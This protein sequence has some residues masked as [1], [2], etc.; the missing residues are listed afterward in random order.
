[1][2]GRGQWT[3]IPTMIEDKQLWKMTT[4]NRLIKNE[5]YIGNIVWNKRRLKSVGSKRSVLNPEDKWLRAEGTHEAIVTKEL[6]D[7][8]N[9]EIAKNRSSYYHPSS[10]KNIVYK[11]LF[12]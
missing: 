5:V 4:I 10:K 8:A 6:F 7:K 9:G 1:M 11:G 12:F 3:K 2:L